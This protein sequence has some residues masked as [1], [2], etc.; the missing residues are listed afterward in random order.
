ERTDN[1][2][3]LNEQKCEDKPVLREID[4]TFPEQ[5]RH[6]ED[7]LHPNAV[8]K[9]ARKE[10][11]QISVCK[12]GFTHFEEFVETLF[13]NIFVKTDVIFQNLPKATLLLV[14]FKYIFIIQQ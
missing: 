14:S 1:R 9:E 4:F 11:L 13:H 8:K 12:K 2:F 7:R 10:K 3:N 6:Q 5:G